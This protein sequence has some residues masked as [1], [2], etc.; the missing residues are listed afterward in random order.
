MNARSRCGA[1][2][3]ARL[4]ACALLSC[5]ACSPA[6]QA[7]G[8]GPRAYELSPQGSQ[9]L[10]LYGIF[11]RGNASFNPGAVAPGVETDIKGGIIEYSHG[12]ALRGKVVTLIAS[13]PAGVADASVNAAGAARS[14]TRSGVGDLE[15]TA[16]FGFIGS[17]ALNEKEYENYQ[18]G[19]A[20][21]ALSRAYFP[22]GAYDRTAPVN[23]GQNRRAVQLGL[24]MSYYIGHSFLDPALTS[25]E[26]QPSVTWYSDNN[27]PPQGNRSSEAPL[28][29]LEA[30][31]TRNLSESL[32]ISVDALL[33]DGAETTID[34]VSQHDRQ[35]SFALGA[36][37]SVAV[38]DTVSATLSYT[39][40]VSRNNDGVSGHVIRVIAAFSL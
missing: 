20:L 34:G 23:P 30:H 6:A 26:L 27:E 35:R 22:T 29:Q 38:N 17:P 8:E 4:L 9:L 18:P 11:A 14:Y 31:I 39:D 3:T 15:L 13:L 19:F 33:M 21:S 7:Q 37:V 40:A 5:L 28:W 24:P 2:L 16:V 10:S 12:C 36:T 32:W 25:F 1:L